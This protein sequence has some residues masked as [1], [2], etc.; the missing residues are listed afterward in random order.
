MRDA[1]DIS[2]ELTARN[3]E[4]T[5]RLDS[6]PDRSR[7]PSLFTALSMVA[8]FSVISTRRAGRSRGRR[9]GLMG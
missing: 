2:D 4:L 5:R 8:E 6:R 3:V 9:R 7:G 1:G